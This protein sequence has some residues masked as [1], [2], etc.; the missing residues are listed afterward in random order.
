MVSLRRN[1]LWA[2]AGSIIFS[3]CQWLQLVAITKLVSVSAAG[4]WSLALGVTAPIFVFSMFRLRQV[5]T[6]DARGDFR[7]SDYAGLRLVALAGAFAASLIITG[8]AYP[9]I[10]VIVVFVAIGKVFD[11]SSDLFYGEEQRRELLAPI[12]MSMIVRGVVA[13]VVAAGVLW[14]TSS[15]AWAMSGVA[16]VFGLGMLV[17]GRR[18][19]RLLSEPKAPSFDRARLKKLFVFVFP[20]GIQSAI[21]SLQGTIPRYFLDG[22]TSRTELG[23][24]SAMSALLVFGNTAVNAIANSTS[25]RLARYAADGDMRAFKRLLAI[26]IGIGAALGVAAV[27]VSLLI[28]EPV[29]RLVY[30]DEVAAYADVLPWLALASGILWTYLF[31]GTALD[32]QRQFR[33]QPWIH[34]TSTLALAG[35][36][37]LL[38]PSH[39]VRGA[40]WSTLVGYSVEAVLYFIAV[41]IPL[42]ARRG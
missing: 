11:A 10:F 25:A 4:D 21:G 16:V 13:A 9:S 8:F 26:M 42:R 27:I 32:A 19:S 40:A 30:N 29:L 31:L 7:W 34:G 15:V 39:G 17:D 33:I 5:Q 18:V 6:T 23:V 35:A 41:A 36:C 1:F 2:F 38:V 28:G 20:I 22:V 12:S 24:W 3:T 37:V 14:R